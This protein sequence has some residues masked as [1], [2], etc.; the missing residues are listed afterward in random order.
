VFISHPDAKLKTENYY[1][2]DEYPC[3]QK[4]YVL[5]GFIYAIFG[6]YDYWD[7][8]HSPES[9]KV[10]SECM[11]T[12]KDH[13]FYYRV[14]GARSYYDLKYKEQFPVYHRIHIMQLRWLSLLTGDTFFSNVA[15]LFTYDFP[16]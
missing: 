16:S 9:Q 14:P 13:I 2:V 5:N 10:F 12:I 6:I 15:D 1:W 7:I 11:T 8:T 3:L 4:R